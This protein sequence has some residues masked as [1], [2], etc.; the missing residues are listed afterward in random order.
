MMV[1]FKVILLFLKK[2]WSGSGILIEPSLKGYEECKKNRPKSVCLNCACVSNDYK[3]DYIEG[4]FK[5]NSPMG[6]ICGN[7]LRRQNIVM[8]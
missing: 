5:D 6:S 3:N 4:D 7:R 8:K 1:Y 2:I